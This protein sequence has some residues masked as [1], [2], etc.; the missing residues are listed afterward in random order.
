MTTTLYLQNDHVLQLDRLRDADGVYVNNA[1]VQC[2]S[3]KNASGVD[4]SGITFP[5]ALAYVAASN[6]KYRATLQDT[7]S[8]VAGHQ[9]KAIVTVDGGGLQARFTIDIKAQVRTTE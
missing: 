6:G 1:T 2:I 7:A 5:L 4:V 9:Y 8:F 3:I